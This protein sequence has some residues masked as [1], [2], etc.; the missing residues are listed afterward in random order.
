MRFLFLLVLV[1]GCSIEKRGAPGTDP[2]TE[3]DVAGST[4]KDSV[5]V[6]ISAPVAA[7]VGDQVP[8]SV[9]VQNN[10]DRHIELSLTGR[11]I[12]FDIIV[13]RSD[14]TIAWQR[15]ANATMQRIV[16]LKTLAPGE[17]F[18][19]SDRWKADEAGVFVIGAELPTDAQPLQAA[20][21]SITIR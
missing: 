11:D 1:A 20:P 10:R 8:I 12:L 14:S 17:S 5:G 15:L 18:T 2:Y 4:D 7:R 6:V 13:A 16:Q 19:L 3:L 9:V 21:V